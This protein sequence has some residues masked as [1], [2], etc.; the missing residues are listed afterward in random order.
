NAD[1]VAEFDTSG[2]YLGNFVAN[3]AG[4]LD[5]PFDAYG[6]TADW[7]VTAIDSDNILSYDLTGAFIAQFAAINTF[8]EQANEAGNSNVLVANFSGTE[9]GVVEYTAA[10]A[11]VGIY[12]PATLGGYRGVYELG[13]GNLLT[14]NGSGVHEIDRS[15][16]LV[17]TK[18]SGVSSRFIEYVAPQNDCTNPA[19]V[20]WLSTDPISGTT[21]AGLGTDVDVTFDSTGLAGGVYNANLC[22]TSN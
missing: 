6:R 19:D 18:I 13:N 7:L 22:I 16:N 8:P 10:G 11:L 2:N 5:S 15:G 14:T 12:D 9:E 17:E 20:P 4:G 3:G 1:A 21:A